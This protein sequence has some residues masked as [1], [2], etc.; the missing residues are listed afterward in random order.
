LAKHCKPQTRDPEATKVRILAAA[1]KEFARY[2]L[3]GARVDR[4]AVQAKSNKRMLYHYFGNKEQLFAI[5]VEN[6]YAT[7]REAEA[8]LQ[9]E[10]HR[11]VDAMRRLVTFVWEYFIAHPE[12]I[13][14]VNSENL[15]KAK[16]LKASKRTPEISR[17][18][19]ARMEALLRRGVAAG[20]FRTGLDAVQVQITIAAIGYYYLTNRFTGEIVFERELMSKQALASRL[21]FNIETVLRMVCTADE[22]ARLEKSRSLA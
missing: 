11:P 9:L 12:F 21:A 8:A 6:A 13:T 14:L 16:H 22:I 19:V 7:F 2:G 4:I 1:E 20:V 15:H 17:K 3:G 5:T 10:H 18:F